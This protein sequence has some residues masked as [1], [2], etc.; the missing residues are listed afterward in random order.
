MYVCMFVYIYVYMY[1]CM[2]GLKSESNISGRFGVKINVEGFK[3]GVNDD[4]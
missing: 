3:I 4:V 2:Y 1:V